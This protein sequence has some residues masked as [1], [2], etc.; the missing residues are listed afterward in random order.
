MPPIDPVATPGSANTQAAADRADHARP[1]PLGRELAARAIATRSENLHTA[2]SEADWGD[3]GF[4]FGDVLDMINPLHH[5]PVLSGVY[6]AV[7]GDAIAPAARVLGAGLFSLN[8]IGAAASM[9]GA[10]VDV[11]LADATGRD[12]GGHLAALFGA[13]GAATNPIAVAEAAAPQ[14]APETDEQLPWRQSHPVAGSAPADEAA[15][16]GAEMKVVHGDRTDSAVARGLSEEQ[17]AHLVSSTTATPAA[18]HPTTT[19]APVEQM[20][21]TEP[22]PARPLAPVETVA[23]APPPPDSPP[24]I[25]AAMLVG[26]DKYA[27]MMRARNSG[28]NPSQIDAAF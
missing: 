18:G 16:V 2:Q 19:T 7:T 11:G 1:R 25:G 24:D 12:A 20:K 3:D 15:P 8:P 13:D 10:I 22:V 5:V 21:A 14:S 28:A 17:W 27:A 26:L 23:M 4:T 9:A 6:R